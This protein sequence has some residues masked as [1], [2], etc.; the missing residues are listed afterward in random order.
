MA[1]KIRRDNLRS[2]WL[3][4]LLDIGLNWLAITFAYAV[5]EGFQVG[6]PTEPVTRGVIVHTFAVVA[7]IWLVVSS[8]VVVGALVA[9]LPTFLLYLF[10]PQP[11]AYLPMLLRMDL[12]IYVVL[13]VGTVYARLR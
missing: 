11:V 13:A 9:V 8:C 10:T 5:K 2:L 4:R 12:V 6:I 3:H 7:L 1:G